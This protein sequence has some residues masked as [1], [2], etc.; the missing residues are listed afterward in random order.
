VRRG[1]PLATRSLVAGLFI[2]GG[3]FDYQ[4]TPNNEF[5][6]IFVAFTSFHYGL[7]MAAGG[8]SREEMIFG[9]GL[10]NQ[11]FGGSDTKGK[12]GNRPPNVVNMEYGYDIF[13][14][15]LLP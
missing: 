12:G 9:A 1:Q 7:C 10:Y 2:H 15:G 3:R 14:R 13:R 6:R 11:H 4:R 8:F 5:V